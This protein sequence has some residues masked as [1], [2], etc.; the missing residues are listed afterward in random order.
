MLNVDVALLRCPLCWKIYR[1]T[2][3]HYWQVKR[4]AKRRR[5]CIECHHPIRGAKPT[6]ELHARCAQLRD[7]RANCDKNRSTVRGNA[8]ANVKAKAG[9]TKRPERKT[10]L[11]YGD[12]MHAPP[13]KA[14]RLID[15]I[16]AG[17]A[18]VTG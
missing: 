9:P 1:R 2:Y 7:T 17:E 14:A 15:Q 5:I 3:H 12:L 13:E 11:N 8:V 16:L 10:S 6:Q 4:D 18:S